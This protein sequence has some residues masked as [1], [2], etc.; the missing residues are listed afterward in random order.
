MGWILSGMEAEPWLD[1]VVGFWF[2]VLA[3]YLVIDRFR[4]FFLIWPLVPPVLIG[5]EVFSHLV[6]R[7][8]MR[9]SFI[10]LPLH[11]GMFS[12]FFPLPSSSFLCVISSHLFGLLLFLENWET[13]YGGIDRSVGIILRVLG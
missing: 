5:V 8:G 10:P 3:V 1:R 11:P 13:G 6:E 12:N 7:F 4:S 2:V 9:C